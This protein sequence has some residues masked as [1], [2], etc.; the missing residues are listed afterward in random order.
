VNHTG[1]I[2]AAGNKAGVFF[3]KTR[4][5]RFHCF[6]IAG[7]HNGQ[8]RRQAGFRGGFRADIP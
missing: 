7:C 5:E 3:D 4:A 6:V 1:K 2:R 8:T